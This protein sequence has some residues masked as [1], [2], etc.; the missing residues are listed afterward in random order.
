MLQCPC[1]HVCRPVDALFLTCT[2]PASASSLTLA[3]RDW[4]L[5]SREWA[6]VSRECRAECIFSNIHGGSTPF[7]IHAQSSISYV[8]CLFLNIHTSSP[9]IDIAYGGLVRFT[10]THFQSVH[11]PEDRWVSTHEYRYG[12]FFAPD[13]T[14]ILDQTTPAAQQPDVAREKQIAANSSAADG[15]GLSDPTFYIA[16]ATLYDEAYTQDYADEYQDYGHRESDPGTPFGH[17]C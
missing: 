15:V 2:M 17:R 10:S 1:P 16:Y 13:D 11:T 3:A 12:N 6:L 8:R 14:Y 9:F 7:R 5:V 4:A